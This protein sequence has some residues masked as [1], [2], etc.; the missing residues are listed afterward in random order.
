MADFTPKKIE[1]ISQL[2]G[3]K[4]YINEVDIPDADDWNKVVESQLWVQKLGENPVDNSEA[5]QVGEAEITIAYKAD[6]TPYFKPKNLKGSTGATGA[7][8][9]VLSQSVTYKASNSGTEIPMGTW[10][11]TVPSVTKGQYLWSRTIVNY[12]NGTSTTTYNVAYQG[13]DGAAADTSKF[14]TTNTYQVIAASKDFL[15]KEDGFLTVVD[16]LWGTA[17]FLIQNHNGMREISIDPDSENAVPLSFGGDVGNDG[18]ILISR[19][20]NKTPMWMNSA[21][22]ISEA[23]LE[24]V[25][26]VGSLYMSIQN[27]SPASFLGGSWTKLSA[28]YALWTASSGAGT[29]ISAGLPNITGSTIWGR[30]GSYGAN[31]PTNSGALAAESAGSTGGSSGASSETRIKLTFDA[32]K[33]GSTLYGQSTTVQPPAYKVYVWRRTA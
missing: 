22:A 19:G 9:T 25:Y 1:D 2:N 10:S 8:V 15:L 6:G 23:L 20:E 28:N 18:D 16:D 31:T 21:V 30:N 13:E 14:V 4:E 32:S 27:T 24:R 3:G 29:T 17:L 5:N 12:S 7:S 11:N 26:P 33:G